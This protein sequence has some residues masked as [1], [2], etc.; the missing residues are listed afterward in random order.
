MHIFDELYADE[1]RA[2][3]REKKENKQYAKERDVNFVKLLKDQQILQLAECDDKVAFRLIKQYKK[4]ELNYALVDDIED[5]WENQLL[6]K[7]TRFRIVIIRIFN[8]D[9]FQAQRQTLLQGTLPDASVGLNEKSRYIIESLIISALELPYRI[10]PYW[11]NINEM[12]LPANFDHWT[13]KFSEGC[14]EHFFRGAGSITDKP[15]Q[16]HILKTA[17]ELGAKPLPK[18]KRKSKKEVIPNECGY[19]KNNNASTVEASPA[20]FDRIR[21]KVNLG[22]AKNGKYKFIH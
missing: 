7:D 15:L 17:E 22:K 1:K 2:K 14:D 18:P 10:W 6:E 11:K 3:K 5:I 8:P 20:H 16:S 13:Q 19:I 9:L 4:E 12:T 21:K